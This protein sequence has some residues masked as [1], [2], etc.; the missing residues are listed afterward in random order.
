[1]NK[2]IAKRL[3]VAILAVILGLAALP[4]AVTLWNKLGSLVL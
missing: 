1:M 4:I 2:D 3:A